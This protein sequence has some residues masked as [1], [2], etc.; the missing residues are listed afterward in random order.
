MLVTAEVARIDENVRLA[1]ATALVRD[2]V[3]TPAAD[4]GPAQ[5]EQAVRASPANPVRRFA[6]PLARSWTR[7]IR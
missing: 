4:L 7:A 3:N 5:L 1:A 2:L 6:S